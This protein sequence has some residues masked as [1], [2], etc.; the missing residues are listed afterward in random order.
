MSS[1]K[2]FSDLGAQAGKGE[3]PRGRRR[4]SNLLE[5]RANALGE[6]ASGA[7]E[8]K[9]L[10][11]V[12]PAICK[13]WTGHNRR[14]ELLNESRCKDLIDG[15]KSQGRQ[16]FPAIVRKLDNDA[17]F[18]YEVVCGA[19]R[20]WTI[21]W[22][23]ENNYPDFTYLIEVRDLTDEEAFRLS[24]I[25][26]RDKEDVS[27]FERATDYAKALG[28]YYATQKAMAS[29]LEVSEAWLSRYLD[30]ASIPEA[31]AQAF[32]D[33]TQIRV[34]H[35]K[36]LKP[37]LK[38]GRKKTKMI[39]R[40]EKLALE[41]GELKNQ[42]NGYIAAPRVVAMLKEAVTGSRKPARAKQEVIKGDAGQ[43]LA[44]VERG[45]RGVVKMNLHVNSA[46]VKEL[47]SAVKR[48]IEENRGQ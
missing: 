16:E 29:R 27:D 22:L 28:A 20:H 44:T 23:R 26:N 45:S 37:L 11:R 39:E 46:S 38:D 34:E 19:R 24:D 12:D 13:M 5:S 14:Y 21:T 17:D 43:I 48:A 36:A 32:G 33:V 6:I 42:G 31:I 10:R 9:Q 35:G 8:S 1:N 2:I 3:E 40:A 47:M 4:T 25:E 18:E 30:L 41:Q 15:I 7:V